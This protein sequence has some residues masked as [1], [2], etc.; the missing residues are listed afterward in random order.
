MIPDKLLFHENMVSEYK[1][2]SDIINFY[3]SAIGRYSY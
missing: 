3:E 2:G 1:I